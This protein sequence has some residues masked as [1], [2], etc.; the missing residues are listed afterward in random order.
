MEI[1]FPLS[2][3][4]CPATASQPTTPIPAVRPVAA[5]CYKMHICS[6]KLKKNH[7]GNFQGNVVNLTLNRGTF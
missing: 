6:L 4:T 1:T 7:P 5:P 3:I 2:D